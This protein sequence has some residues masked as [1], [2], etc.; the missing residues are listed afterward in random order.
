MRGVR[1]LVAVESIPS[2]R[3][4]NTLTCL[5]DMYKRHKDTPQ[6]TL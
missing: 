5:L 4:G 2:V 1:V 3:K 6:T